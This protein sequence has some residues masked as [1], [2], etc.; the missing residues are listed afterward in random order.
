[1][2]SSLCPSGFRLVSV[3]SRR[4]LA[5]VSILAAL[6]VL[7]SGAGAAARGHRLKAFASCSN[8]VHYARRH[9]VNGLA[10]RGEP[11]PVDLPV[12][13][14]PMPP[15][16]VVPETAPSSPAAGGGAGQDFSTTNVQESGVDEP[17]QVKT[18]GKTIFAAENGRLYAVDARSDSPKLLDSIDLNG[19]GQELLL[20]GDKLLVLSG[21]PII[22]TA[23]PPVRGVPQQGARA[24]LAPYVPSQQSTLSLVDVSDPSNLKI[25][26][27][28]SV[29]GGY[30]TA[31]MTGQTARVIFS[32]TPRVMPL[33]ERAVPAALHPR[34]AST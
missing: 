26:K 2:R 21:S 33:L 20:S 12:T 4:G 24:A 6:A 15:G 22:Y 14:G 25:E 10:T 18:D 7:P 17:D 3:T 27:T 32:A 11:I 28:M 34:I 29:D 30:L 9:A 31:R 16:T 8:F 19:F 23:L 1:M 13:R 5:L